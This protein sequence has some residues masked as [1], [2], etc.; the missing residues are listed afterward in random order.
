MK[1]LKKCADYKFKRAKHY[2]VVTLSYHQTATQQLF[3]NQL[4][5]VLLLWRQVFDEVWLL[6]RE[7]QA[8]QVLTFYVIILQ[9]ILGGMVLN[10]YI[11]FIQTQWA[12]KLKKVQAIKTRGSQINQFHEKNFWP[13]SIFLRFQKWP[14]INFCTEKKFKNCQK[15]NFTKKNF[16]IFHEFFWPGLF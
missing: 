2:Y 9:N 5:C 16:L 3:R 12:R 6:E 4:S 10:F 13:N 1:K 11:T 7:A 15:C 8:V 14:K